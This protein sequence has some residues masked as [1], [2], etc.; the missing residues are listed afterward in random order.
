M[1]FQMKLPVFLFV[2][3]A[4]QI[5][6]Q[7]PGIETFQLIQKTDTL[8]INVAVATDANALVHQKDILSPTTFPTVTLSRNVF[9]KIVDIN[10]RQ[11]NLAEVVF[12][13]NQLL[14]ERDT[15][16][17]RQIAT[18]TG[19]T[20]VQQRQIDACEQ[21]NVI[22][23]QSINSL[24]LQLTQTRQIANDNSKNGFGKR[25]MGILLGGGIGLGL[26]VILGVIA[27]K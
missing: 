21:T 6:A 22:L 9:R 10:N 27:A 11:N 16:N 1:R 7:T 23:N 8:P 20:T 26:G 15:L 4:A 25:A 13:E 3:L 24:N 17:S 2:L 14:R 5:A 12:Q 18:L 19:I